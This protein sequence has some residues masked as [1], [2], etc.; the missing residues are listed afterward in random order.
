MAGDAVTTQPGAPPGSASRPNTGKNANVDSKS[1]RSEFAIGSQRREYKLM[2]VVEGGGSTAGD[3]HGKPVVL[4]KA[5]KTGKVRPLTDSGYYADRPTPSTE[6][7]PWVEAQASKH[8]NGGMLALE[9][10]DEGVEDELGG[11]RNGTS[12]SPTRGPQALPYV[13]ASE[14]NQLLLTRG[15]FLELSEAKAKQV[16]VN[17]SS[18]VTR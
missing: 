7:P 13:Y 4:V 16:L 3:R 15:Q 18:L 1:K 6:P 11:S 8:A 12:A 14:A 17:L 10:G 2:Q 9:N 5:A